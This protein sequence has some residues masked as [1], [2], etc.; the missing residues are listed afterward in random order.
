LR[1][2]QF[3]YNFSKALLDKMK[4]NSLRLFVQGQNLYTATKYRGY[5]PE[6]PAG[7]NTL[8]PG[9]QYPALKTVTVGL[10]IGL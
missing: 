3:S 1:N 10:S 8:N 9:A 6:P 4:I 7:G 5:D 2:V